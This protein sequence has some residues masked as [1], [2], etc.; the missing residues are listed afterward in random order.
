MPSQRPAGDK[1]PWGQSVRGSP[2]LFRPSLAAHTH[3]SHSDHKSQNDAEREADDIVHDSIHDGSEGLLAGP[4]QDSTI[5]A[6]GAE[7]ERGERRA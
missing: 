2:S 4:S 3:D 7:A 5:D 6:L 1:Q